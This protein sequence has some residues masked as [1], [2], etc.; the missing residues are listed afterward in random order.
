MKTRIGLKDAIPLRLSSSNLSM[1]WAEVEAGSF[2]R[3]RLLAQEHLGLGLVADKFVALSAK[4]L[5]KA[6]IVLDHPLG[7]VPKSV[8]NL[9]ADGPDFLDLFVNWIHNLLPKA[10]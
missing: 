10:G 7:V 5:L 9:A 3:G 1:W 8:A 2:G 4:L 6:S